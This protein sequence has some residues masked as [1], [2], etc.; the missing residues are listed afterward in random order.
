MEHVAVAGLAPDFVGISASV[1]KNFFV[2]SG[3]LSNRSA[4]S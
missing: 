4:G 3:Y 1:E 2:P